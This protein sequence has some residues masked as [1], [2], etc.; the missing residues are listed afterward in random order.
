MGWGPPRTY[1]C[2]HLQEAFKYLTKNI[3]VVPCSLLF[4]D[5]SSLAYVSFLLCYPNCSSF[6][7]NVSTFALQKAFQKKC[8]EGKALR[9]VAPDNL[10]ILIMA[11]MSCGY[12]QKLLNLFFLCWKCCLPLGV[13]VCV[14]KYNIQIVLL[15]SELMTCSVIVLAL[16]A[17]M[18]PF[19][20]QWL[21]CCMTITV[22]EL[23]PWRL[24]FF[25]LVVLLCAANTSKSPNWIHWN[26][27]VNSG[28]LFV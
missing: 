19:T 12:K 9:T 14:N 3:S 27:F 26:P 17:V 13:H 7:V 4:S 2:M 10:V 18:Y 16:S 8:V 22:A 25:L 5:F 24:V 23:W 21:K 15:C 6:V 28:E 20:L 11:F 1:F